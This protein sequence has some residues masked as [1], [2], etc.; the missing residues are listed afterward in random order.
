[1]CLFYLDSSDDEDLGGASTVGASESEENWDELSEVAHGSSD[2]DSDPRL[3]LPDGNVSML[4]SSRGLY[5]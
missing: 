1:M 2:D 4:S 5:S 3:S